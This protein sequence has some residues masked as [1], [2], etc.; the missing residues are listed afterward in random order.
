MPEKDEQS[1]EPVSDKCHSV[2]DGPEC[3]EGVPQVGKSAKKQATQKSGS[4]ECH[5][6]LDGPEC[7]EDTQT[8]SAEKE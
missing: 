2:L 6:V 4:E 5:S 8:Q 1:Q 3:I 7:I